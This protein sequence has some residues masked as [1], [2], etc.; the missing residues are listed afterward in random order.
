M[1]KNLLGEV[2]D[3]RSRILKDREQ[4][5]CMIFIVV[6][7]AGSSWEQGWELSVCTEMIRHQQGGSLTLKVQSSVSFV[8]ITS[9]EILVSGNEQSRSF[10][11]GAGILYVE[12]TLSNQGHGDQALPQKDRMEIEMRGE[13]ESF[14]RSLQ[15]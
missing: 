10:F 9:A 15:A 12:D 14:Q 1:R 3:S 13:P 8:H 4:I 5:F 6:R 7:P 2:T 11:E